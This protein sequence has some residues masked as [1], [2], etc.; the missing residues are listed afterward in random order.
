MCRRYPRAHS[1]A[2]AKRRCRVTINC[3][4]WP[5]AKHFESL[6]AFHGDAQALLRQLAAYEALRRRCCETGGANA[7][8][9]LGRLSLLRALCEASLAD[10]TMTRPEM[11]G[12]TD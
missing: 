11:A 9:P 6:I 5:V 4:P 7:P 10:P 1:N 3:C 12:T 2:F 8:L